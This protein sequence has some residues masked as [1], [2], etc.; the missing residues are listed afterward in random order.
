MIPFPVG[1]A[2]KFA[3]CTLS[4][5]R[6]TGCAKS[7]DSFAV[8]GAVARCTVARLMRRMGLQGAVRGQRRV[9]TVRRCRPAPAGSLRGAS[10]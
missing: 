1:D 7:G 9:K 3:E 5:L 2:G 4:T 6:S 8:R 10:A